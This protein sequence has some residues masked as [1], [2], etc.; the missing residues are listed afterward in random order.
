MRPTCSTSAAAGP[1]STNGLAAHPTTLALYKPTV[2]AFAMV[3]LDPATAAG[4]VRWLTETHATGV[5]GYAIGWLAPNNAT[6]FQAA[7]KTGVS[8]LAVKQLGS[9]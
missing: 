7:P 2:G 8:G 5:A 3:F 6:D 9:D 4:F 1:V